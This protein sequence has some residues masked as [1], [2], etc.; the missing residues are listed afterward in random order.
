[1]RDV[2]LN[3]F[4]PPP[5]KRPDARRALYAFGAAAVVAAA[6][7]GF[8]LSPLGGGAAADARPSQAEGLTF[9]SS[10]DSTSYYVSVAM[11]EALVE[12]GAVPLQAEPEYENGSGLRSV[13]YFDWETHIRENV[14]SQN[15][16]IVFFMIG[17]N[18]ATEGI[19]LDAYRARVARI[20]DSLADVRYVVWTG[21]PTLADP[22]RAAV[23]AALNEIFRSE[24]NERAW[25]RYVDASSVTDDGAGNYAQF[26]LDDDGEEVRAR[27]DDGL[28]F[29]PEGGALLA[30]HVLGELFD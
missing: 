21:Q 25:V 26:L 5:P 6:I 18:D 10:G 4:T 29:T 23:V 16:D 17:A 2:R 19:D 22:D 7:V 13:D 14:A 3:I 1:M 20:M 11:T 30:R 12:R 24:A 15:P 8:V 27:E 28:H 9:W